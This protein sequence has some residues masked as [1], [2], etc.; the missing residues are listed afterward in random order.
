ME[1]AAYQLIAYVSL[2]LASVTVAVTSAIIGYWQ[3]FG[4]RPTLFITGIGSAGSDTALVTFE[5]WNR[6]KY[7]VAISAG[8]FIDFRTTKLAERPEQSGWSR[9]RN[10]MTYYGEKIRL[11]P[12]SF[13]T[14]VVQADFE[15]SAGN[16]IADKWL[17]EIQIFDPI[18]NKEVT[19]SAIARYRMD[20]PSRQ[21]RS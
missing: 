20:G 18:S 17:V 13:Q 12:L 21:S 5:V 16:A 4:W 1:I 19:L 10:T 6:R 2:T 7:P 14:F 8:S 15:K 3:M 11:E 9:W